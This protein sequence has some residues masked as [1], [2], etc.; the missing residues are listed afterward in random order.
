M[1]ADA[2]GDAGLE[3]APL[4]A[5]TRRALAARLPGF[6]TTA[7]PV[8]IT[9]A[10]LGDSGLFGKVLP[11]LA[12]DPAADMFF[13][14]IPVAGT[15]YDV[16]AIAR[17]TADF[18]ARTG[19]PVAVAAWQRPVARAFRDH[20]VLTFRNEADAIGTL[21][22]IAGHAAMLGQPR[23]PW[24]PAPAVAVPSGSGF[25]NEAQSLELLRAHGIACV[26][27]HL[28]KS[29]QQAAQAWQA[30]AAS[31]LAPVLKACS[32]DVPHKSEHGLVALDVATREQ[33]IDCFGR[34]DRKLHE[35]G[36]A[37]EGLIVA[38]RCRGLREFMVGARVDPVFGP[39]VVV[40]DGGKYVEAMDDC[41]V[42][43]PPF[44]EAHVLEALARLRIAPLLGGVRGEPA[45]DLRALAA[46]AVACGQLITGAQGRITSLDL[47]PVIV[48]AAG[49]GAVAVDALVELSSPE[50]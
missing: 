48:N 19:K 46:I 28:C 25:L 18:E 17:D 2:A 30:M 9:A 7:N 49:E 15:G 32:R 33:A 44:G 20:G 1:G 23:A 38:A 16:A 45:P 47:N 35:L 22:Q 43:L 5:G 42:L 41:A 11:E 50:N 36:A 27:I 34:F 6:A 12:K 39:L 26:A 14:H 21:A 3:L 31:G 10:L 29:A 24:E 13:I 8:D 40:G 4:A 37:R